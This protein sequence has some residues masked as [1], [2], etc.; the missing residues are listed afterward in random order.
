[1]EHGAIL[2]LVTPDPT[3]P[4]IGFNY[5]LDP[6]LFP[7]TTTGHTFRYEV[8]GQGG[9]T[10]SDYVEM[11]VTIEDAPNAGTLPI[12]TIKICLDVPSIIGNTTSPID[13]NSLFYSCP[14]CVQPSPISSFTG[15]NWTDVTGGAPGVIITP[16]Q[17]HPGRQLLQ[18][19]ILLDILLKF[20]FFVLLLI[21]QK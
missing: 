15:L 12:D 17:Y 14:T 10:G 16:L 11:N 1:M 21:L 19:H 9:C 4:F 13:L 20:H 3:L 18:E 6:S 5:S 2:E 7:T 8:S